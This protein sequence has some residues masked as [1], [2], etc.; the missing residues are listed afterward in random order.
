MNDESCH[1][2]LG[3][4]STSNTFR[5]AHSKGSSVGENFLSH[6]LRLEALEDLP[7]LGEQSELL[8]IG[9]AKRAG[10]D[11][12]SD[13]LKKSF[14]LE[15]KVEESSDESLLFAPLATRK[16]EFVIRHAR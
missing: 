6:R 13:R 11:D 15:S 14:K 1:D 16:G 3:G 9:A 2:N 7:S 5:F 10:R 8:K 12:D 4:L